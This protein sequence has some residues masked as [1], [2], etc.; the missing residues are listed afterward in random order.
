MSKQQFG[1]SF[2]SVEDFARHI[3]EQRKSGVERVHQA[4]VKSSSQD[5]RRKS[6]MGR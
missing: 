1:Q 5:A 6:R 3:K 4:P 2:K